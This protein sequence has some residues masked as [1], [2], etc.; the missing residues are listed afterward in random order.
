[1]FEKLEA[2]ITW[3]DLLHTSSETR[4]HQIYGTFWGEEV[5]RDCC[6][7]KNGLFRD[8]K[9]FNID[10]LHGCKNYRDKSSNEERDLLQSWPGRFSILY[11]TSILPESEIDLCSSDVMIINEENVYF[12]S[13]F[14]LPSAVLKRA[15]K[16]LGFFS[17]NDIETVH[18]IATVPC[19]LRI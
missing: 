14:L 15:L 10:S 17:T 6:K 18:I 11:P 8:R 5:S 4:P 1:M 19:G 9:R 13:P 16:I 3:R 2:R 7:Q 12:L